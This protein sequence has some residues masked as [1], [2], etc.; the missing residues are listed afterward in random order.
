MESLAEIKVTAPIFASVAT[1]CGPI[2]ASNWQENNPTAIGP[3][4]LIDNKKIFLGADTDALLADFDRRSDKC[5]FSESG[6]IKTASAYAEAIIKEL[7]KRGQARV[8][9]KLCKIQRMAL[10]F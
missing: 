6:Q 3:K 9:N 7:R 1:K 8:L 5:H 10:N 4:Q 2:S